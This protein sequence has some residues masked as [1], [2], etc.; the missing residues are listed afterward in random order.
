MSI[1]KYL[2]RFERMHLL[3]KRK[4]TGNS[5]EFAA[6]MHIS[7][8]QLMEHISEMKQL[9]APVKYCKSRR[10]YHY[11]HD[12]EPFSNDLNLNDIMGGESPYTLIFGKWQNYFSQEGI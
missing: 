7:R 5:E 11:E 8:S 9:G 6:K 4:S 10:V 3:I 12:W 1:R 2:L